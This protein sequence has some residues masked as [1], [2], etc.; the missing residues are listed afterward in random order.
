[1]TTSE[2]PTWD[3][4]Q[5]LRHAG[6]PRPPLPRPPRPRR[7]PG[8]R[9]ASPTSAAAPATSPPSSPTAGPRPGSPATT[10]PPEMLADAVAAAPDPRA[11]LRPRR[12][13]RLDGPAE[14][15]D[16]RQQRHPAVGA[17]PPRRA[18]RLVDAVAPRRH[19]RLPGAGQLDRP[20]PRRDARPGHLARWAA[21]GAGTCA[22]TAV[23]RPR[24]TSTAL[25]G[26][27]CASTRGRPP[28]CTCSQGEDPVLAGSAGTG[29]RPVLHALADD[30][31]AREAFIAAYRDLLAR[32]TRSRPCGHG[33]A[34]PPRLRPWPQGAAA[35]RPA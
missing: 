12:P 6:R 1:M 32:P 21:V 15:D 5:Y 35:C 24:R 31:E 10:T 28:T 2:D 17:G 33:P 30:P 19:P 9:P 16:L 22:R 8:T 18:P 13:A 34:V 7:P 23:P 11:R 3:P 29:L 4:A 25:A 20:E 27:G 14:T 26:T